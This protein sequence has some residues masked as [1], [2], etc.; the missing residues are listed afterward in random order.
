ML[1]VLC[2]LQCMAL[3]LIISLAAPFTRGIFTS[4]FWEVYIALSLAAL[5]GLMMGLALSA[6]VPNSDQAMSFIPVVL[7]PQVVFSGAIFP[8][9][10]IYL[11]VI[12]VVFAARWGM[13]SVGSS[14]HL[15]SAV[16]GGDKLF[17]T[18]TA[19]ATYRFDLHYLLSLWGVLGAMIVILTVATG[20][21]LKRKDV[22][23][24]A[25]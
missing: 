4:A 3:I 12:S 11:Q 22:R 16:M 14:V 6:L 7:I 2:L 19:C 15:D 13:A 25:G 21:L 5:A 8:L 18:C 10:A 20:V 1:G 24:R 17:G 9:R 23:Q